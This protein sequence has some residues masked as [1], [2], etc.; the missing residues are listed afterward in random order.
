MWPSRATGRAPAGKS[1]TPRA[2]SCNGALLQPVGSPHRRLPPAQGATS[3]SRPLDE[4]LG[5]GS[6]H[7]RCPCGSPFRTCGRTSPARR[8]LSEACPCPRAISCAGGS[9]R[10]DVPAGGDAT[11]DGDVA[12]DR[13][14]A[15]AGDRD[16]RCRGRRRRR[17]V[18]ASFEHEQGGGRIADVQG[19]ASPTRWATRRRGWPC[20][21]SLNAASIGSRRPIRPADISPANVIA[22]SVADRPLH[23][24]HRRQAERH[25]GRQRAQLLAD[26]P[27]WIGRS[28]RSSAPPAGGWVGP[29]PPPGWRAVARARRPGCHR[30]SSRQGTARPA[31]RQ[32]AVTDVAQ[33][34]EGTDRASLPAAPTAS[35][36]IQPV[37]LNQT[38]GVHLGGRRVHLGPLGGDVECRQPGGARRPHR[39]SATGRRR[40]RAST[41]RSFSITRTITAF[42]A[43]WRGRSGGCRDRLPTGR[44][45]GAGCVRSDRLSRTPRS[46][47]WSTRSSARR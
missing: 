15:G 11:G 4:R 20:A 27:R 32:V 41:S 35:R 33:D 31:R 38:T 47:W 21:S 18:P 26:R 6:E 34:V 3:R 19:Q 2:R 44:R 10:R 23:P 5:A 9:D 22:G 25:R 46:A 12:A 36:E 28:C 13:N 30:P 40:P 43:G 14:R 8:T 17:F 39:G 45:A 16:R 24:D 1:T 37:D 29:G 7:E 42:V